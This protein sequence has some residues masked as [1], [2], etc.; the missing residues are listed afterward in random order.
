MTPIQ[1][2]NARRMRRAK[3]LFNLRSKPTARPRKSI[4]AQYTA[5]LRR[6]RFAELAQV[7]IAWAF[8]LLLETEAGVVWHVMPPVFD[9]GGSIIR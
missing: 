6:E 8:R 5:L 2:D 1:L 7:E 3:R 9:E 4:D